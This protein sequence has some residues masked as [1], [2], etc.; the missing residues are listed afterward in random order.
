MAQAHKIRIFL[1]SPQ[2]TW[3]VRE[4]VASVVDEINH[5]PLQRDWLAAQGVGFAQGYLLHRPLPA[6]ALGALLRAAGA[7]LGG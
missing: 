4:V 1:A 7:S 5:D 2:D 3:P 6:E